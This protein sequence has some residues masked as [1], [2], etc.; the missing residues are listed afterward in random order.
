MFA[1]TRID[2]LQPFLMKF[3]YLNISKTHP[4]GLFFNVIE[5]LQLRMILICNISFFFQIILN[6][7]A[8]YRSTR[9]SDNYSN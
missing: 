7:G 2:P 3:G 1:N 8:V 9:P 5:S 6:A 4:Y